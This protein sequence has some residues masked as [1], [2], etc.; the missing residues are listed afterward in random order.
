MTPVGT[1]HDFGRSDEKGL[2]QWFHLLFAQTSSSAMYGMS[3]EITMLQVKGRAK[4]DR[5]EPQSQ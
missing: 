5:G 4:D 3:A 1:A 2:G